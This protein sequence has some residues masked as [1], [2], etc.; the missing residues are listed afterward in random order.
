VLTKLPPGALEG[1]SVADLAGPYGNYC[2]KLYADLGA[3]VTLVE[4]PEGAEYRRRE[5]LTAEGESLW[6]CYHN[7]NKRS[8]VAST[9]SATLAAVIGQSDVLIGS[10]RAGWPTEWGLN[11]DELRCR[12]PQLVV[13]SVTPFGLTGPYADFDGTDIVCSALGGLLALGGYGDG[14][15]LQTAGEQA[16][17]AAQLFGAVGGALAVLHAEASGEGQ[18]V[19]VSIQESVA[20]ALEHAIQYYDLER[21]ERRRQTGRQRGA[22]AGLYTCAD[23]WVY[24]FVGGIASGRFWTRFVQWLSDEEADGVAEL[25]TPMWEQ[26]T[27]FDTAEAKATFLRIFETF[28]ATRGKEQLYQEAQSRGIPLAPVREPSEVVASEQL[29]FREFFRPVTTPAG[30]SIMAPGAPYT[31]GETP[32]LQRRP[33]PRLGEHTD[34]IR[35]TTGA[36]RA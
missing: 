7:A 25:A 20:M 27:Y 8:V 5:P 35:A 3:D 31:L 10:G 34:E 12:Q 11:L 1:L 14:S 30:R 32:W 36:E 15:P 9:G 2:G 22:G 17:G 18:V 29:A 4:P 33:A 21:V 13:V 23:G 28:T 6:F 24:L 19:D 26:R 16:L